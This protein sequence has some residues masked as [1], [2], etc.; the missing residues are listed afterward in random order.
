MARGFISLPTTLSAPR[1]SASMSTVPLPQKGSRMVKGG[2]IPA[3][4]I[5]MRASFG[6]SMPCLALR[7]GFPTSRAAQSSTSCAVSV[8][9]IQM[10]SLCTRNTYSAPDISRLFFLTTTDERAAS[11]EDTTRAEKPAS[12]AFFF[13]V[14]PRRCKLWMRC[15]PLAFGA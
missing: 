1:S 6:G 11:L 12:I 5:I 3:R 10:R 15:E 7:N 8:L 14:M 9:P 2:C 13:R 4:L